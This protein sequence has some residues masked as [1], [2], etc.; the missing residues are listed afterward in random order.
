MY[1]DILVLKTKPIKAV[2]PRQVQYSKD[3]CKNQGRSLRSTFGCVS[4]SDRILPS[5]IVM[6]EMNSKFRTF[7]FIFTRAPNCE[8]IFS[9][10]II[11]C[12]YNNFFSTIQR[13]GRLHVISP[14]F[15]EIPR[16]CQTYFFCQTTLPNRID[17]L[18]D[19]LSNKSYCTFSSRYTYATLVY[20]HI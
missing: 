18:H 5:Q 11:C 15:R 1:E 6:I 7:F 3:Y 12:F 16:M 4:V 14:K 17:L 10:C 13:D 8:L 9:V 19:F 20:T 2:E